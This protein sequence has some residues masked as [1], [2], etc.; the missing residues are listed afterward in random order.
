[1]SDHVVEYIQLNRRHYNTNI[2]L[3]S[4]VMKAFE[5]IEWCD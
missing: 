5:K 2:G 3:S 4:E 1:M